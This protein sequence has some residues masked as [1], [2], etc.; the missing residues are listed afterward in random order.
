MHVHRLHAGDGVAH[1]VDETC[2]RNDLRHP[3]GHATV[4]VGPHVGRRA[5]ADGSGLPG[6]VEERL[7][8][9][10]AAGPVVLSD[11]E[12]RLAESPPAPD[13][14]V[15]MLIEVV[16]EAH[17]PGLHRPDHQKGRQGHRAT[18]IVVFHSDL[19][20]VDILSQADPGREGY[21]PAQSGGPLEHPAAD[22]VAQL[23]HMV[24][25]VR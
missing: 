24:N 23:A 3:L 17:G 14:D 5:L 16:A 25:M 6:A 4:G 18:A 12:V 13:E 8:P 7:V 9:A 21:S 20:Q 19:R 22:A 1:H 11:E 15:R 2:F 10:K